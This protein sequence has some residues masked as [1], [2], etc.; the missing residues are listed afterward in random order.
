M[1]ALNDYVHPPIHFGSKRLRAG[2]GTRITST[3]L[4]HMLLS[5]SAAE[6]ARAPS[7]S[8]GSHPVTQRPSLYHRDDHREAV[9][10][11]TSR[12]SLPSL[13]TQHSSDS[14]SSM[15]A[16]FTD[17]TSALPDD[18]EKQDSTSVEPTSGRSMLAKKKL[19]QC[20]TSGLLAGEKSESSPMPKRRRVSRAC[21]ECRGKKIK[22]DGRQPCTHCFDYH[23]G[24]P[25]MPTLRDG[26]R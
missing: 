23:Y 8:L 24:K 11:S 3:E 4:S 20:A 21:D 9:M 16:V 2:R 17:D 7:F 5:R 14:A 10:S 13:T 22:C 25:R 12:P 15:D 18:D 1:R 6:R 19:S 26:F